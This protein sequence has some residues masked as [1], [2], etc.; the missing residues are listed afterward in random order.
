MKQR[1][2]WDFQQDGFGYESDG[3]L[4][5]F[6]FG[7]VVWVFSEDEVLVQQEN[8]YWRRGIFEKFG[9]FQILLEKSVFVQI[10]L[11]LLEF[12]FY[13]L[14]FEDF[15]VCVQFESSW[16]SCS[17]IFSIS[18]VFFIFMLCKFFLEMDIE[19]WVFK[20]F[21]KYIQG[22][23]WWK[24]FIVNMLVWSSEFIK[25]FMIVISDWYVKKEVCEFFKLI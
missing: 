11:V 1:S 15:G 25:K 23:F 21:N 4:L 18:C 24:V 3:V 8:K 20:Y 7:L 6:M 19:N 12:Y 9:F 22:F 17:G 13:F 10:N 2:S 5:L 14:Q 16:Q